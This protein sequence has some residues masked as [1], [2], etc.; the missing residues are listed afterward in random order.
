MGMVAGKVLKLVSSRCDESN[1]SREIVGIGVRV[2]QIDR[3]ESSRIKV[4]EREIAHLR[5]TID[6]MVRRKTEL[7]ERRLA[8]MESCNSTLGENYHRMHRMY[9]DL[10]GK[11]Q[12]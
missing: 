6:Q 11:T 5:G 3:A 1:R 7:L 9:L 12:A 2:K 8:I 10:L 4:L